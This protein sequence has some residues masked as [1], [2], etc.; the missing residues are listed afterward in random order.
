[1][2]WRQFLGE[3]FMKDIA[4]LRDAGADRVVFWFDN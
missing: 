3:G 2:T 1:M 4:A